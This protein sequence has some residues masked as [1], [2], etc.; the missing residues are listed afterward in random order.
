MKEDDLIQL[1][2]DAFKTDGEEE[3]LE[4]ERCNEGSQHAPRQV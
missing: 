4:E 3:E 2:A 1:E